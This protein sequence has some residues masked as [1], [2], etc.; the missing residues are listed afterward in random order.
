MAQTFASIARA[1]PL[2]LLVATI[3]GCGETLSGP[4]SF[5]PFSRE[6]LRL[7]TGA[8]AANGQSVSVNY[9]LWLY[10][11]SAADKNAPLTSKNTVM[12]EVTLPKKNDFD[13]RVNPA[14]LKA[15]YRFGLEWPAHDSIK[16]MLKELPSA[17]GFPEPGKGKKAGK[18]NALN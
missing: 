7:G 14:A 9:T 16:A 15:G 4:S 5:A 10:D 1:L 6:D 3:T 17:S 18:K 2:L 13:K 11:P 8:T 12:I